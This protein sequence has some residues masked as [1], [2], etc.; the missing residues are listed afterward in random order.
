VGMRPLFGLVA[1][2]VFLVVGCA[3]SPA[4]KLQPTLAQSVPWEHATVA[5]DDHTITIT[6]MFTCGWRSTHLRV[7]QTSVAVTIQV[8][9]A[10]I[11]GALSCP[12]VVVGP[13]APRTRPSSM[14]TLTTRLSGPLGRRRLQH[15]PL[16]AL[17]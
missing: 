10:V 6:Y 5:A 4:A 8:V 14:A 16:G 9:A 7:R 17:Q 15:G 3:S 2:A 11:Q 13:Q 1:G 12:A